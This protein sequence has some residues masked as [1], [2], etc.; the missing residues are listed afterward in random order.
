MLAMRSGSR[1]QVSISTIFALLILPAL[2]LVIGFSYYEN[3]GNLESLQQR[4]V[5]R[6]ADDA[7]SMSRNLLEPVAATLH[8]MAAAEENVPG[9]YRSDRSGELLY[10]ALISAP[11]IDAVY[12]SF[13]DGY[14]RVVTRMDADRRRTDARIPGNANWHMS[15][16]DAFGPAVKRGRHRLFYEKW[17]VPIGGF[18]LDASSYDVRLLVPQYPLAR[19]L[20]NL[21]VTD[22]FINPDTGSPVI[23]LGY[24]VR[25]DGKFVGVASAHITL[26][27][28]TNLL[29]SRKASTNSLTV[30]FDQYGFVLGFPVPG[31]TAR[32]I[33][34]QVRLTSLKQLHVPQIDEAVRL[35]AAGAGDRF[36]FDLPGDGAGYVALF[37]AFPAGPAKTWQAVVVTPTDDFVGDLK[38]TNRLLIWGAS[39]LVLL[40]GALIYF[41]AR[42]ISAPIEAV[43]GA[44]ERIRSL[45]FGEN[46]PAESPILEVFQLQRATGLLDNALRSFALFAPVG[47]VRDLIESGRPMVPSVEQR[48]LTIFFCD[49]EGFTAIA[50]RL[51]AA[52]LSSQASRYFEVVTAAI[53]EE[54]GTVDKFIGDSMMAFWGAPAPV[55]DQVLRGCRAAIRAHRRMNALNAEWAGQGRPQMRVR[56]GLH[57][58][59]VVVGN[60]G[61]RKRLSYTVMGD[62]VNVASRL[63]GLNKQFGTSICISENVYENVAGRVVARPLSRV[64]VKGRKSEIM[65][66]ELLDIAAAEGNA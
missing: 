41:M 9:F 29:A 27:S 58:D 59:T 57:C 35:R 53:A 48:F 17:P 24:P 16:I 51:S 52:D 31:V 50:E 42:K 30:I 2:A 38:R 8:L 40:E 20:G 64:P 28:L 3:A 43:S 37:T 39:L 11:Q 44:I 49:V 23:A 66:Y 12:M 4:L 1:L 45:S 62:G 6:A 18:S 47:L 22:P 34:G 13:E 21:A 55:D 19:Q 65:I 36:N 5:D 61:S 15:Y 54:G 32:L 25:V 60:V 14:H 56:I 63:E 26:D 7:R 33:D 10:Q 46:V